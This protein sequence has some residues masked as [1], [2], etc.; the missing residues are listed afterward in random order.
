MRYFYRTYGL[1]VESDR[2]VQALT[3][4]PGEVPSPD[5][6][7]VLGCKPSWAKEALT[8][9][10][11]SSRARP[12]ELLPGDATF[13]VSEY[14]DGRFFHLVYGDGTQFVIDRK[15]T[16]LWGESG[17]NLSHDD[18][19]VYLVGPV[20]G[21][22]LR[23]RGLTCLHGSALAIHGRAFAL[24]GEAG[25]GKSTTA[26]A[27]ALR[28]WPVL[29]EDVCALDPAEE[30][31]HVRP[32]YPRICLWSDSVSF[33]FA[34]PETLPYIVRGWDK[35]FLGLDGAR[36]QFA[37]DNAPLAAIFLL[38]GR[39]EDDSAPRLERVPQREAVLQ[40]VQNTYMNWLLST[41]QRA[42]EFDVLTSLVSRAESFRVFP[43]ADP[44]RIAV[45]AEL[46]ESQALRVLG[47]H[48]DPAPGVARG[49]V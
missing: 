6:T 20:M 36:A 11:T 3:P 26:A 23:Q 2:C 37:D 35:R 21:F 27:L 48:P 12:T 1:T 43:S 49:N 41:N 22:I 8:L 24:V 18:L 39:T 34:S 4:I 38:A 29:C 40:L 10:R 31:Y 46:I 17:P 45:L 16:R 44:A 13:T 32:G 33:L 7:F 30:Q 14:D 47:Q 9:P 19:C 25:A 42:A 28:G 15:V 5:L